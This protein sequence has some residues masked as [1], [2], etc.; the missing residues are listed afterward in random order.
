MSSSGALK[1]KIV[2][3]GNACKT[4]AS[5]EKTLEAL[6]LQ[7]QGQ[8]GAFLG[9]DSNLKDTR[10]AVEKDGT[11]RAYS[12]ADGRVIWSVN[13]EAEFRTVNGVPRRGFHARARCR[14]RG[15]HAICTLRLRRLWPPAGERTASVWTW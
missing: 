4:S 12:T 9:I 8:P 5:A 10:E 14:D 13:T 6:K 11:L 3:T 2:G 1:V 15:L 7:Y